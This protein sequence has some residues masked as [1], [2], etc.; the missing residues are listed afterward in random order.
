MCFEDQVP[1]KKSENAF[2]SEFLKQNYKKQTEIFGGN[3]PIFIPFVTDE[4]HYDDQYIVNNFIERGPEIAL[5]DLNQKVSLDVNF[6]VNTDM[7][8]LPKGYG[9]F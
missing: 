2:W 4:T 3:N 6:V 9:S 5:K 7:N 8:S 1:Q